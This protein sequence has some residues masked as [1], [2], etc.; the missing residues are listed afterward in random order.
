MLTEIHPDPTQL[1]DPSLTPLNK[2]C[3]REYAWYIPHTTTRFQC[4]SRNS[5]DRYYRNLTEES[6]LNPESLK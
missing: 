5:K 2:I 1:M 6:K 4:Q 3:R